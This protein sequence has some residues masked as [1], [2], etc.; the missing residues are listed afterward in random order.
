M[1]LVLSD[2]DLAPLV[3]D[4]ASMG[5]AMD[6]VEQATLA[7]RRGEVREA[8]MGDRTRAPEPNIL[9]VSMAA[10]DAVVTGFQVFAELDDGP[11]EPN[12]RYVVLLHRESRQ[13]LAL[14]DYHSLSPLRV[15]A[16]SGVACRYLTPEGART[17]GIIGSSRQARGQLQAIVRATP[18]V[19]QAKVFSPTPAHR[20]A[21]ARETGG[22]LGLEV[23]PVATTEEAVRSAD[24]VA[25]AANTT[26]PVLE[27]EWVKPGAL[28]V[29]ISGNRVPASVLSDWRIVSTNWERL[30]TSEPFA[31]GIKAGTFSPTD[32]AADLAGVILREKPVRRS[33]EDVVMF[34]C[35]RLNYWAVAVAHWA[36][37]W[38]VKQGVGTP[39]ALT[40]R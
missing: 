33:P 15:G 16:S 8:A 21:F 3:Q 39:F 37:Q 23:S 38:G 31:T 26:G 30:V 6:A 12:G 22:W 2:K 34:D 7:Y 28:V 25:I 27:K 40:E 24:V 14:V 4:P 29:S 1:P 11:E 10:H 19:Q 35:G 9:S 36:Y 32:L 18:G 20:E 13:L 5:G 17:A